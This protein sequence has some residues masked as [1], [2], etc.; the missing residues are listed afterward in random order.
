MSF[1]AMTWATQQKIPAMQKIVLLMLANRINGD[2]GECYPSISRLSSECGMTGRALINQLQ[3]LEKHGYI[4]VKRTALNGINQANVY[5][6]STSKFNSEYNSLPYEK[7]DLVVNYIHQGSA[8]DSLGVVNVVPYGSE[9]RSHKPVIEP[10]ILTSN[11]TSKGKTDKKTKNIY[12]FEIPTIGE[13]AAYI[14]TMNYSINP[15][16]FFAHYNANGWM[17]GRVKMKCWKSTIA[18]WQHS[19]FNKTK[20][21]K[22]ASSHRGWNGKVSF[23]EAIESMDF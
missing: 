2:T 4:Q 5:K 23:Q 8:P 1:Q 11:L 18:K 3:L 14:S 9:P 7:N 15:D 6:L 20:N 22:V 16:S 10:V 21:N 13:I 12:K 19:E 17:V